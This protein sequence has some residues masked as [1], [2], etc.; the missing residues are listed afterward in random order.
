MIGRRQN[1][2]RKPFRCSSSSNWSLFTI[3]D[4]FEDPGSVTQREN[5]NNLKKQ[6]N[7]NKAIEDERQKADDNLKQGSLFFTFAPMGG[8]ANN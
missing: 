8:G 5:N 6:Y 1:N 7:I 4:A 2:R 3:Q